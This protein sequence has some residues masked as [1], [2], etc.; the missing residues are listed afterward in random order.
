MR[1]IK[2]LILSAI[3]LLISNCSLNAKEVEYTARITYY[4]NDI[5]WGNKVACQKQKRAIHGV[6]IAAHPNFKFGTKVRIP[7]LKKYLGNENFVVH[8]RGSAVTS[9]KASKNGEYVFDVYVTSRAN[10]RRFASS[11][12]MYMKVYVKK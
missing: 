8:D 6:T 3:A 5:K 10:V 12:P 7:A 1:K 11:A 2:I 9:K 4:S